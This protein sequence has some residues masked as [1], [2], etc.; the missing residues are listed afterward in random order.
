MTACRDLEPLLVE[1]ASGDLAQADAADLDA[2]LAGCAACRAEAAA[3]EETL[4]LA[5]LPPPGDEERA[6]VSGLAP[7]LRLARDAGA[8]RRA[9]PLR[10][11]TGFAVA[12]AAAAFL[13]APVFTLRAPRVTPEEVAAAAAAARPAAGWQVPDPDELWEVAGAALGEAASTAAAGSTAV[14]SARGAALVAVNDTS[15][16]GGS[17]ATSATKDAAVAAA[18]AWFDE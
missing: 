3:L 14:A 12:A 1:R 2:H 17:G 13:V 5:R 6:A 11:A 15:G 8:H 16:A 18:D 7:A 4:S 9:W 10:V